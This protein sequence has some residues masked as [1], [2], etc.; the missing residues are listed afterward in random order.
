MSM[1]M[2]VKNVEKSTVEEAFQEALKVQNNMSSFKGNCGEESSKE[3]GKAKETMT[4]PFKDKKNYD[5]MDMEA[6]QRIIKK[7]SNELI[8][9]KKN[10]GEGSSSLKKCFIFPP[11]K[12][13]STPPTNK[14]NPSQVDVI[15]ME[16]IFQ[17]LQ[18]WAIENMTEVKDEGEE[19][20]LKLLIQ[21]RGGG[22]S[23][24]FELK[25]Y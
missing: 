25:Q 5:S 22:E 13:K 10:D 2:F 3:K 15:N 8:D 1:T 20:L 16:Y 17:S 21:L 24:V 23:V 6:L 9:W 11:Q 7:I 4:K 14:T 19:N 18:N 12:Y